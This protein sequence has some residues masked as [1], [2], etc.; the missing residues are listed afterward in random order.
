MIVRIVV[1]KNN[2]DKAKT[3]RWLFETLFEGDNVV[4]SDDD[5]GAKVISVNNQNKSVAVKTLSAEKYQ[6]VGR[7][8]EVYIENN[9][10]KTISRLNSNIGM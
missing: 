8:A 2:N 10:G 3:R 4:H 9:H 6:D 1:Y 7:Y 5:N